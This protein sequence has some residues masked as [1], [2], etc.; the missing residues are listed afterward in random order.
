MTLNPF[1]IV[2]AQR[3]AEAAKDQQVENSPRI[4]YEELTYNT[5]GVGQIIIPGA[6]RFQTVFLR[7]PSVVT[8]AVM[9]E[10][11]GAG[12]AY[13][14]V[15]AGVYR[16]L[17]NPKGYFTG[18]YVYF[19][20]R[21]DPLN[22]DDDAVPRIS[23]EEAMTIREYRAYQLSQMAAGT[24]EA[25]YTRAH[26]IQAKRELRRAQRAAARG[27]PR[28][29]ITHHLSFQGMAMKDLPDSVS[30]DLSAWM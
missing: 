12:W 25:N 7:A 17:T 13:P 24:A 14:Q 10:A 26:L 27:T 18:V 23:V 3:T 11:P 20:V 28:P 21:C 5:T 30:V 1:T 29:K 15:T 19:H 16:W 8:G 6:L 2:N 9:T 4:A 22:A